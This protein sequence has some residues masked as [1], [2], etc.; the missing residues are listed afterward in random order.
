MDIH[1][2]APNSNYSHGA[3]P[4]HSSDVDLYGG[5]SLSAQDIRQEATD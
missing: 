1:I 4:F 5:T 3:K 2:S